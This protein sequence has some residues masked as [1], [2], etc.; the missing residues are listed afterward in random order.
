ML[1]VYDGNTLLGQVD[2]PQVLGHPL[3]AGVWEHVVV[4]LS[5]LGVAGR[6]LRDLYVQDNS[7]ANQAAAY[8]DDVGLIP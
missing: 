5:S 2:I 3:R 8:V 7:G 1:A 6:P 4:S